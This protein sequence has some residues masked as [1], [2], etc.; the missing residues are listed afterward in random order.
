MRC[1]A[2]NNGN[3]AYE[4]I[5]KEHAVSAVMHGAGCIG[6]APA[7]RPQ[8]DKYPRLQLAKCRSNKGG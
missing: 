5:A 6:N 4:Y 7:K 2:N 8:R 3:Q 1:I